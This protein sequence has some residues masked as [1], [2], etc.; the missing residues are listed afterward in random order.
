FGF[1]PCVTCAGKSAVVNK[2]AANQ[3]MIFDRIRKTSHSSKLNLLLWDRPICPLVRL[4]ARSRNLLPSLRT[5]GDGFPASA[6]KL[7]FLASCCFSS[8]QRVDAVVSIN[9]GC[10]I[11]HQPAG[12][13]G[14]MQNHAPTI[15]AYDGVDA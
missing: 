6:G 12:V 10:M 4:D 11:L 8:E 13:R 7:P 9:P 5:F 14:R 15:Y 2:L 1:C 3:K